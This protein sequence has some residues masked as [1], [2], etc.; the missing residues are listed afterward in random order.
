[1]NESGTEKSEIATEG[2]ETTGREIEEIIGTENSKE[3]TT[4]KISKTEE[5][6]GKSCYT[7]SISLI[8]V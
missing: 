8:S 5:M 4:M 1:M 7:F 2:T 3:G 6:I